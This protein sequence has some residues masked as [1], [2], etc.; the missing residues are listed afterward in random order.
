MLTAD[1]VRPSSSAARATLPLL[2]SA[3]NASSWRIEKRARTAVRAEAG[4]GRTSLQE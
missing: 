4:T 1:C 3:R 2:A